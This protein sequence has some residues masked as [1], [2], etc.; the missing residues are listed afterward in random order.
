MPYRAKKVPNA[1]SV[2]PTTYFIVSRGRVSR[3]AD[4]TPAPRRRAAH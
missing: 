3:V 2:I 1:V 4:A